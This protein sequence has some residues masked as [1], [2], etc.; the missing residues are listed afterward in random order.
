MQAQAGRCEGKP[1]L[2]LLVTCSPVIKEYFMYM[3]ELSFL[4]LNILGGYGI[5][6]CGSILK[7]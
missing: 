5:C 3:I 4:P 1:A 7:R 2:V 6:K